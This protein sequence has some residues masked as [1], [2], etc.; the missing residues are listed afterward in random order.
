[1]GFHSL[2]F[3]NFA[4]STFVVWQLRQLYMKYDLIGPGAR[5]RRVPNYVMYLI[6]VSAALFIQN[7][8]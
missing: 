6:V 5:Q 8:K 4:E 2:M 1:M 7:E 3:T